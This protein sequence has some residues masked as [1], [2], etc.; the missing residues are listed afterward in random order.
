MP[1][2]NLPPNQAITAMR[3][4]VD[5][6]GRIDGVRYIPVMQVKFVEWLGT[7]GFNRIR[8]YRLTMTDGYNDVFVHFTNNDP[9]RKKL[10]AMVEG[11]RKR[12]IKDSI[13]KIISY[14]MVK[15]Q[16]SEGDETIMLIARQI[17]V[18]KQIASPIY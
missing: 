4:T 5:C 15:K 13:I 17:G 2:S 6:N 3:T 1:T 11:K 12:I 9:E 16:E 7:V 18:V 10:Y 14:E 8:K